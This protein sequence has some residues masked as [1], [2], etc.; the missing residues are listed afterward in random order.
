MI[1]TRRGTVIGAVGALAALLVA[2][3]RPE[4]GLDVVDQTS[5]SGTYLGYTQAPTAKL[6]WV[7]WIGNDHTRGGLYMPPGVLGL[8]SLSVDSGTIHFSSAPWAGGTRFS[9]SG[10]LIQGA[11]VG[12]MRREYPHGTPPSQFPVVFRSLS[13]G[14]YRGRL[15]GIYS[16]LEVHPESGDLIGTE[17][18]IAEGADTITGAV[19]F[20]EGG[21][22]LPLLLEEPELHGDTLYFSAGATGASGRYAA[23][24][25]TDGTAVL[26]S[27]HGVRDSLP[28]LGTLEDYF[29]ERVGSGSKCSQGTHYQ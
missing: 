7:L 22:S 29:V 28:R 9:F 26:V 2:S 15:D 27:G 3:W 12:E 24:F 13:A 16:N 10:H 5:P 8:C 14:S 4:L 1:Q 6:A 25:L 19:E 23:V 11:I 18:I 17:L 21:A 20:A